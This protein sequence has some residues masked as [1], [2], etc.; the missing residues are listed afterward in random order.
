MTE[1]PAAPN[2]PNRQSR[3][4]A[5]AVA[6]IFALALAVVIPARAGVLRQLQRPMARPAPPAIATTFGLSEDANSSA[7]DDRFAG[8]VFLHSGIARGWFGTFTGSDAFT[9]R[10]FSTPFA[11]T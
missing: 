11:L 5:A 10:V 2:T 9:G 3:R 4:A 8:S 7:T 1:G 6:L